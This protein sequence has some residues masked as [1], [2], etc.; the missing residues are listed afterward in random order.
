LRIPAFGDFPLVSTPP[1]DPDPLDDTVVDETA[2]REEIVEEEVPPEPG[3]PRLWPWLLA[4]LLIVLGGLLAYWLLLREDAKTTM[5]RVVGLTEVQARARIAEAEL[6]VDVDR[7]LSDRR[8]GIVFAQTPGAGVQLDEG[9]RVEIQV[10]SGLTR[11]PVP[12]V[13]GQ[14]ERAAVDALEEAG[15]EVQIQR[16]FAGAPRRTV[17]EQEPRGGAQAARGSTVDLKVSK[18]RNL[19]TVPDVLGLSEEEAVAALREREFEPRIFDV[20]SPDPEGTVVAQQPQPGEEAP[21]DSRVRI[22]VST[23]EQSGEPTERT[24]VPNVVGLAQTPA[25]RRLFDAGFRGV[26]AYRASGQPR[27]RVIEQRSISGTFQGRRQVEVVVSS[28]TGA[29]EELEVPDVRDTEE[30]V[31]RETLQDAGFRVEVIRDGDGDIVFDQQPTPD[32]TS[33]R[34]AVVTIFVG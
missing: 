4:L 25:L 11:V 26:V 23:G 16:V 7:D 8:A 19:N 9:E 6:E 33:T 15:F 1:R 22:N 30:P 5:P 29:A 10:S 21:P 3:P 28:G 27:G 18:G 12:S 34:G 31:A 2:R 24:A 13:V 14:R 17:V 20:P 32:V